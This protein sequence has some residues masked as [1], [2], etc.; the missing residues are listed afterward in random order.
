MSDLGG[1]PACWAHL[2]DELDTREGPGGATHVDVSELDDDVTG[3]AW[4]L[5][6]GGDL[7]ANMIRLQA[8]REIE[9]HVNRDVDVFVVVCAGSG[10]V[11][12]DDSTLELRGGVAVLIPRGS[13]RAIRAGSVGI[14][15][16]SIHRRRDALT[17]GRR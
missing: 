3:A 12:V 4:S 13:R 7:D 16:F 2:A 17:I 1:E 15:Y 6:H 5:P 11:A 14:G 8:G 9:E 10:E